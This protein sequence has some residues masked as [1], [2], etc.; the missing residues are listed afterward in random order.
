M[1]IGIV[2]AAF[3]RVMEHL[4]GFS[5]FLKILLRFLIPRISIGMILEGQLSDRPFLFHLHPPGAIPPRLRNSLA[6]P[7]FDHSSLAPL[8]CTSDY[9]CPRIRKHGFRACQDQEEARS[10]RLAYFPKSVSQLVSPGKS[11]VPPRRFASAANASFPSS[12]AVFRK[13]SHSSRPGSCPGCGKCDERERDCRCPWLLKKS[14]KG[15]L[16]TGLFIKVHRIIER[17]DLFIMLAP[18]E[19]STPKK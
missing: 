16:G 7:S 11:I 18:G 12:S 9:S 4:I 10:E 13:R 5:R 15:S 6:Y 3:L 2:D 19:Q 1:P 14:G 8:T 17:T